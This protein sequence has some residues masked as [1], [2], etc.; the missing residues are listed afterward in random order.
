METLQTFLK[1]FAI[2]NSLELPDLSSTQLEKLEKYLSIIGN[3]NRKINLISPK[4]IPY[5]KEHVADS[6]A[7]LPSLKCNNLIDLGSGGGFPAIP[8]A[9]VAENINFTLVEARSKR[10]SF[11]LTVKSSLLLKNITIKNERIEHLQDLYNLFDCLTAR[12]FLP[13][14]ELLI[15]SF[16]FL[17]KNGKIYAQVSPGQEIPDNFNY[18]KLNS[19]DYILPETGRKR[20]IVIFQKWAR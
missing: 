14:P 17:K 19:I 9:I 2:I 5:L 18:Q 8:L 15:Q 11:L 3:W 16:S 7:I 1:N 20:R 4:E 13:L 12:A 10:A 6:L